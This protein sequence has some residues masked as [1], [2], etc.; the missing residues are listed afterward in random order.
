MFG[1]IGGVFFGGWISA[2]ITGEKTG[3]ILDVLSLSV[4]PLIAAERLGESRIED[5]DISRP[6]DSTF[7]NGS[8]LA[9]GEDEP[10]LATYYVS[11]A[12][13][14]IL[15]IFLAIRFTQHK[16]DGFTAIAFL[17]IFGA[18]TIVTESLRYDRFLSISFVGIQQVASAM[19][20]TTGIFFAIRNSKRPKSILSAAAIIS[21]PVMIGSV[22]GLEFALDRTTW[23]KILIYIL[24]IITV[25]IPGMLGMKLLKSGKVRS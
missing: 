11:A 16:Q 20:L 1:L 25:T 3:T 7:L 19:M 17:I 10:C 23:N 12:F 5:F 22:I 6:L 4:L 21:L 18:G 24:M 8:F 9:V 13:A 15:F 14:M 2:A